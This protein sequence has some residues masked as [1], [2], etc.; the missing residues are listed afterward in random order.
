MTRRRISRLILELTNDCRYRCRFCPN[1][2]QKQHKRGTMPFAFFKGVIDEVCESDAEV[3]CVGLSC[4]GEP[5]RATNRL[6]EEIGY[7]E[8]SDPGATAIQNLWVSTTTHGL[9]ERA[10]DRLVA[11]SR[12]LLNVSLH[13]TDAVVYR[14][15]TGMAM[16]SSV[17][18]N[19]DM[20][21]RKRT[22]L[23][24]AGAPVARILLRL[25]KGCPVDA[26][27]LDRWQSTGAEVRVVE[28]FSWG[29]FNSRATPPS[30]RK[31]CKFLWLG[32]MFYFD[33]SPMVC[34]VDYARLFLSESLEARAEPSLALY[35]TT[36]ELVRLRK[37][38]AQ[39][40]WNENTQCRECTYW[41]HPL[42]SLH[43][44]VGSEDRK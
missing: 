31:A 17:R 37:L 44:V 18:R 5:L 20:L 35:E 19:I 38:H 7:V 40:R 34:P 2:E 1:D 6:L 27:L 25:L 12:L 15:L 41:A 28:E 33:G 9:S 3:G 14:E 16:Y 39:G 22:N 4:R 21:L 13:T 24:A 26:A 23:V 29:R 10:A 32:P 11:C 43:P 36:P 42:I 8:D 30:P